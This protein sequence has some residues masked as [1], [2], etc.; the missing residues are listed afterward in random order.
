MAG[1]LNEPELT[2]EA[3]VDGWLMTGDPGRST[4]QDIY[5]LQPQEKT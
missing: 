3:I 2:A 5:N 1:Y 4:T